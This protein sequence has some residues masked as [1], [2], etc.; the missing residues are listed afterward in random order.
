MT[1]RTIRS[2]PARY[3]ERCELA[4]LDE[5]L[6]PVDG[7]SLVPIDSTEGRALG[8]VLDERYILRERI[9]SGA[10]GTVY[11]GTEISTARD[12]AIKILADGAAS[13][14]AP[15]RRF[16]RE[17]KLMTRVAHPHIVSI[18]EVGQTPDGVFYLVMDL[19]SGRPLDRVLAQEG[20]FAPDRVTRIAIQICQALAHAHALSVV[21]RDLKPSNVLL[22]DEAIGRDLVKVVD[23]G[24]AKSLSTT[25]MTATLTGPG[26]F[27]GTPLYM[28]PEVMVGHEVDHRA[29]LY[30]LGVLLYQLS[31]G[32]L[33]IEAPSMPALAY[34]LAIAEPVPAHAFGVPDPLARVIMSLLAKEP[35][36][37]PADAL[38]VAAELATSARAH[39]PSTSRPAP[40]PVAWPPAPR[41]TPRLWIAL[42]LATLVAL[43]LLLGLAIGNL[44]LER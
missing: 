5:A 39:G 7:G 21:H 22:L 8:R 3:C 20:P 28:A 34:Q 19:L 24:I 16:L 41:T 4:Y 9:G 17:A 2:W 18:L 36:A 11:R 15:V 44:L 29:D 42:G 23:F 6:C 35:M 43:A 27:V 31:T 14:D 12:V 1:Q 40:A 38:A 25:T 37:R 26:G 32:R 10:A 13:G 30:S 33:P